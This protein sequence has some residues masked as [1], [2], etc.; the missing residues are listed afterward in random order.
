MNLLADKF[1]KKQG[2]LQ[3]IKYQICFSFFLQLDV[4]Y[5]EISHVFSFRTECESHL[6]L[7]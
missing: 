2:R 3:P 5:I 7:K 1:N 6:F 4:L